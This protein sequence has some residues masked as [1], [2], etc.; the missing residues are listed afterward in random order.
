V[1]ALKKAASKNIRDA[2]II[3]I[4]VQTGMRISELLRVNVQDV[5]LP[6][7][8]SNHS[9]GTLAIRRKGHIV[10]TP[11]DQRAIR[12]LY[13]WLGMRP[14]TQ[15]QKLFIS[16]RRSPLNPRTFQMALKKYGEKAGVPYLSPRIL[17]T[18]YNTNR[19]VGSRGWK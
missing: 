3:E 14:K 5:V 12:L 6:P 17:Q 11:I 4:L 18:I 13:L 8:V 10:H 2:T 16:R 1:T 19:T 9:G 15:Y 7:S